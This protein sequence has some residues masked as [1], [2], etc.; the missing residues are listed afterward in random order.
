MY[1][2]QWKYSHFE[3]EAH[4]MKRAQ[5]QIKYIINSFLTVHV[6]NEQFEAIEAIILYSLYRF[7]NLKTID[8]QQKNI[9]VITEALREIAAR[10][11]GLAK[12]HISIF[13]YT[14]SNGT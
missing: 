6:W 9:Y 8:L 4:L 5:Y 13:L 1:A 12:F 2:N 14:S 11:S 10:M 7:P 3:A